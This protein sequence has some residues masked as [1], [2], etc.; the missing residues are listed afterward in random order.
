MRVLYQAHAMAF[1][2]VMEALAFLNQAV[3]LFV[4]VCLSSLEKDVTNLVRAIFL[5]ST[6]CCIYLCLC[7]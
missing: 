1:P 6:L 4:I 3:A 5:A 2:V 7:I